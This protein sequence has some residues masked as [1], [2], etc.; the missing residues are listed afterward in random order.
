[1][2]NK[3][4]NPFIIRYIKYLK[5]TMFKS[6]TPYQ[7]FIG[8]NIKKKIKIL[9]KLSSD[10]GKL[11]QVFGQDF[12]HNV[13]IFDVINHINIDVV[14]TSNNSVYAIE[15]RHDANKVLLIKLIQCIENIFI[16]TGAVNEENFHEIY[17]RFNNYA[18]HV[19]I[20][21]YVKYH[22]NMISAIFDIAKSI[23]LTSPIN[24][25][26]ME[27]L[28]NNDMKILV[29]IIYCYNPKIT[30]DNL[31]TFVELLE[32]IDIVLNDKSFLLKVLIYNIAIKKSSNDI[33]TN[34]FSIIINSLKNSHLIQKVLEASK[35]NNI[36]FPFWDSNFLSIKTKGYLDIY[37][38]I[39]I[40]VNYTDVGNVATLDDLLAF[41]DGND[42]FKIYFYCL[43]KEI[44]LFEMNPI[45][46]DHKILCKKI[47]QSKYYKYYQDAAKMSILLMHC[48]PDNYYVVIEK[49]FCCSQN[50]FD[51]IIR[52]LNQSHKNLISKF[53][54]TNSRYVH[55]DNVLNHAQNLVDALSLIDIIHSKNKN[56]TYFKNNG[57]I[58]L[59]EAKK[60]EMIARATT[61]FST[62]DN[63][64]NCGK[65]KKSTSN[66]TVNNN[67]NNNNNS[68][69]SGQVNSGQDNKVN[70]D[71]DNKDISNNIV[72]QE[73][74]SSRNSNNNRTLCV[75]CLD[76]ERDNVFIPCSHIACCTSCCTK[77]KACPICKIEFKGYIKVY[78]C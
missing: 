9:H 28:T 6:K 30:D 77:I 64:D 32:M 1:M 20:D 61:L 47:R 62:S 35:K 46:A 2:N 72:A 16:R 41:L 45:G 75:I 53:L 66:V 52:I 43:L 23:V 39:N 65:T 37:Q 74:A 24:S 19:L 50:D 13:A 34:L 40:V 68:D 25:D 12:I 54:K 55:Y 29:R 10:L 60:Q 48:K 59:S 27:I 73:N 69:I 31:V 36:F 38:K 8:K 78:I 33:K 70:S 67:N 14:L 57:H 58:L 63:Q 56:A 51:E 15:L 21:R 44:Y 22:K 26:D 42:M 76:A 18:R 49:V 7:E 71:H 3:I 17:Q 5:T 4:I 11:V